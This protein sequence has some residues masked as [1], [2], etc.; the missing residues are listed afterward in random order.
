M[1][2]EGVY[3]LERARRAIAP[4]C[5]QL[6]LAYRWE[7]GVGTFSRARPPELLDRIARF[8]QLG[9]QFCVS[10]TQRIQYLFLSIGGYLLL[11]QRFA[12]LA[13]HRFQPEHVLVAQVHDGSTR[14]SPLSA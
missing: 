9:T 3:R 1:W 4:S 7:S 5:I 11:R 10:V 6:W 12:T 8:T 13:I 2:V 14:D